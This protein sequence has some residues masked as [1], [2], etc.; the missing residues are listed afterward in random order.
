M[1]NLGPHGRPFAHE[2]LRDRGKPIPIVS[3]A[4]TRT[5][6]TKS[7][8]HP[9]RKC[10]HARFWHTWVKSAGCIHAEPGQ[11]LP[12]HEDTP[13]CECERFEP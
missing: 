6:P 5:D 13:R 11:E 8:V 1:S 2:R 4:A 9:C 7:A 3:N 10:G 12:V